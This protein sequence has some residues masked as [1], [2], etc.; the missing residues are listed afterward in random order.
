MHINF[1]LLSI[2][3]S[4]ILSYA[5][6]CYHGIV[7]NAYGICIHVQMIKLISSY[8]Y[9]ILVCISRRIKQELHYPLHV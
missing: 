8:W 9:K 4:H 5:F 3:D 2:S 6:L 1:V 7:D